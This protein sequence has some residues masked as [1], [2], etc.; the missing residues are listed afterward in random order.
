ME[1]VFVG[2]IIKDLPP[3]IDNAR[4]SEGSFIR[5]K[6]GRIVL[7]YSCFQGD[8]AHDNACS[9]IAIVYSD[10]E[11]LTF[12]NPQVVLTAKECNADNIMS[13]S[14]LEMLDGSVGM[15]YIEKTVKEAKNPKSQIYLR[16]TFNF[17]T[18][19][20]K[21]CCTNSD[22][23]NVLNNDR[24]IRIEN[25][26]ILF[27]VAEIYFDKEGNKKSKAVF[28]LSKD[29]GNTFIRTCEL[30]MPF[31]EFKTGLQEPGVVELE[32]GRIFAWFRSNM[33]R[34]L[35]SYSTDGGYVFSTPSPSLLISPLSP[36]SIR[37]L[38]DGRKIIVY[39]PFDCAPFFGYDARSPLVIRMA[40]GNM[41]FINDESLLKWIE[42]VSENCGYCYTAIFET[43]D[44]ILLA[45]C[46]GS[47]EEGGRLS[48]LRI[49]RVEKTELEEKIEV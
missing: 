37:S 38:S 43:K 12:S 5:L 29:D 46:A 2:K 26:N 42:D 44:A 34:I 24:V 20:D 18:F 23:Y 9:N 15:F 36:A 13:V 17:N 7:A 16:K 1:K 45:Y 14:L 25:G 49:R 47:K 39:N 19:T 8:S 48:R 32:D 41:N 22:T 3:T 35:K 4:N 6:S 31:D 28:Y 10:D 40:D 11:G 21:I 30:Y 27:C 33:G